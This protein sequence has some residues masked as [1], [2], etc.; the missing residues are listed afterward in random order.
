LPVIF[1]VVSK[2]VA[3]VENGMPG[4]MEIM[5]CRA[6]ALYGGKAEFFDETNTAVFKMNLVN[7]QSYPEVLAFPEFL[8][9]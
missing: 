5:R 7:P 3:I 1:N 4:A 2:A 9:K 8:G 6:I